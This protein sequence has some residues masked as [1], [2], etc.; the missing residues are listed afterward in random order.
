MSNQQ[1]IAIR[2]EA[3]QMAREDREARLIDCP[4]DGAI[5]QYN[6][7][8]GL[9]SCPMGNYTRNGSADGLVRNEGER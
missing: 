9:W 1:L 5:L 7:R 6:S 2:D 8:R 3:R 4:I